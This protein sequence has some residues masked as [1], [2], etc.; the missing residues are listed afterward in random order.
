VARRST[1]RFLDVHLFWAASLLASILTGLL[2]WPTS[3]L[4]ASPP[5]GFAANYCVRCGTFCKVVAKRDR[6]RE[7]EREIKGRERER[8]TAERGKG[9]REE[10]ERERER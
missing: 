8:E 5:L 4:L 6:E 3:R 10:R 9:E 2:D 7:R 1:G